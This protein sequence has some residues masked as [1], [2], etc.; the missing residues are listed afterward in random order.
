MP[1]SKIPPKA[2]IAQETLVSRKRPLWCRLGVSCGDSLV[3]EPT[4]QQNG[5]SCDPAHRDDHGGPF[6]QKPC[7]GAPTMT[8]EFLFLSKH[9]DQTPHSKLQF[10]KLENAMPRPLAP[11]T[12]NDQQSGSNIET[13][14]SPTEGK[15]P[16]QVLSREADQ[17]KRK[18]A[19]KQKDKAKK[20]RKENKRKQNTKSSHHITVRLSKSL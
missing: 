2:K 6:R 13:S 4:P 1:P 9:V 12:T 17:Q 7:P 5:A 8:S 20:R 15:R 3:F 18:K 16:K 11:P 19:S 10:E 14:A